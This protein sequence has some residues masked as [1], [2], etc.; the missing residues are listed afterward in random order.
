M[1]TQRTA[2]DMHAQVSII[3]MCICV[4]LPVARK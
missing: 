1:N 3:I 4:Y 2:G